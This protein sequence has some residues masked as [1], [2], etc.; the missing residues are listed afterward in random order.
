MRSSQMIVTNH[1]TEVTRSNTTQEQNFSIKA[2][3][4]A[5]SILSS[6]LYSNKILAVIREISCNAYDAH[7]AAGNPST[8]IEI[9]LPTTLDPVFYVK[10][11]GTGLSHDQIMK[12]YTTY[13]ES[14]KSDSNDFIGAL[15]LGSK[16]PYSYTNSYTVESRFNGTKR[17]YACF[18]NEDGL[19]SI[20]LMNEAS[21]D[22]VNGLTVMMAVS[23]SDINKFHNEAQKA[24]MYFTPQP[25]VI[26]VLGFEPYYLR[27]TIVGTNWKL[28]ENDYWA[29]MSGPQVVQGFV[30][31]PIDGSI[32]RGQQM[33]SAAYALTSVA[34]DFEVPIGEV[35]VAASR[36]ALS[37]EKRTIE[38]LVSLFE[39]AA[40]EIRDS[41][42]AKF[43]DCSNQW[44]VALLVAQ[45]EH[46]T[47]YDFRSMYNAMHSATPFVWKDQPVTQYC[48]FVLKGTEGV[49]VDVVGLSAT[50][51]SLTTHSSWRPGTIFPNLIVKVTATTKVVIDKR[52]TNSKL[53]ST[54][55]DYIRAIPHRES[56]Q[57]LIII[58]PIDKNSQFNESH[59]ADVLR[60]LGCSVFDEV[61]EFE[62][63]PTKKYTY[64][65]REKT[66]RLA[67]KGFN[68]YVDKYG[69][70]KISDKFSRL[71][72]SNVPVDLSE[73]G[74]YVP[75]DRFVIQGPILNKT[76]F[77]DMLADAVR[78]GIITESDK[79]YG[80]N[81]K[82]LDELKYKSIWVNIFDYI[83]NELDD[84]NDTGILSSGLTMHTLSGSIG[85]DMVQLLQNGHTYQPSSVFGAFADNVTQL[86]A[87][88]ATVD[89]AALNNLIRYLGIKVN[90]EAYDN[91][92]EE[93]TN[94]HTTY[95][96]LLDLNKCKMTQTDCSK[97]L[98]Y[99]ELVDKS[100]TYES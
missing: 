30:S 37:Y 12:L 48:D 55:V 53:K 62:K 25:H 67:W 71:C 66:D 41:I 1:S 60:V 100:L 4:T 77:G 22:E 57:K 52:P 85:G 95:E 98:R 31:Y 82:Q 93:W 58:K 69:R 74:F 86:G 91:L 92:Y 65:K 32:L 11:F 90:R 46:N 96:L 5:F 16:S 44:E 76:L 45:M 23:E 50:G 72:W 18:L 3:K 24:L 10:D 7:V 2:S 20:L 9:K 79:I 49:V 64:T 26:G 27:H 59:I 28:R 19:P 38:N 40:L 13:F 70:N 99:I 73:G 80:F 89:T 88:T 33:T 87:Q 84:M 78:V 17:I 29:A 21:T 42:Q 36:E 68:K 61:I 54:W 81:T 43:D 63:T 51:K 47:S 94:V 83:R 15:G 56:D 14:S 8:P 34:I 35:D 75:V 97:L 39:G 6:G